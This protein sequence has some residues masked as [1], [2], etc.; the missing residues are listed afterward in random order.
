[1]KTD[2]QLQ[3]DVMAELKWEPIVES[4]DIGVSADRGVVTLSG[5]V[6]S[7]AEKEAA[8]RAARRVSGVT[9]IAE[10]LI[11]RYPGDRRDSDAE[12]ARRVADILAWNTLVPTNSVQAK[13]E[14]GFVTLTGSVA[15]FYQKTAARD[16]V[17]RISGVT[18]IRNDVT[19]KPA[20]DTF[21]VRAKIEDA[22][23][24]QADLD[25]S[26]IRVSAE[27]H[28]VKLSGKVH[29]WA[30][31]RAAERAAWAAPGVDMV[32]DEITVSA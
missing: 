20:V 4:A 17:S 8:E 19:I 31:R 5:I 15:W 13:V 11:V 12:I 22:I 27:G 29:S 7:F 24:R 10:D 3:H 16:A 23:K 6:H 30:E 1:M 2:S 21:D 28:K 14:N 18:G 26:T 9:A 25:A 32:V